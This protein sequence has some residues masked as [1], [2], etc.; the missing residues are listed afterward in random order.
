VPVHRSGLEYRRTQ[1]PGFESHPLR[2]PLVTVVAI[3]VLLAGC[4]LAARKFDVV[5]AAGG[6][7]EE[8]PVVLTDETGLVLNVGEAAVNEPTLPEGMLTLQGKPDT[9]VLHWVG[10]ACDQGVAIRVSGSDSLTIAVAITSSPDACDAI[11]V[12]RGVFIKIIRPFDMSR[13]SFTI[14][15]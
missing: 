4:S 12:P 2:H 8:L 6:T 3:A 11:G 1:V 7:I 9:V 5:L 10:G 13:T 15:R 14:E